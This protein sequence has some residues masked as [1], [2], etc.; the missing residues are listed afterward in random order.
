MGTRRRPL[1]LRR[2]IAS[3][4]V[5]A[6]ACALALPALASAQTFVVDTL[7]DETSSS[8]YACEFGECSLRDAITKANATAEEDTIEFDVEGTIALGVD[9][10]PLITQPLEIDA[11]TLEAY[12]GEPLVAIDGSNTLAEGATTGLGFLNGASGGGVEG[13]AIGGFDIG[14]FL[15]GASGASVCGN[16]VGIGLDGTTPLPNEVGIETGFHS[17]EN[18]I[19]A[20]CFGYRGNVISGN[21]SY[22]VVDFGTGTGIVNNRIGVDAEGDPDPNGRF[23]SVGAGVLVSSNAEGPFVGGHGGEGAPGNVI[24]GNEGAG[25][26]VEDGASNVSIRR[27]SIAANLLE[28]IQINANA[29]PAPVLGAT[30]VGGGQTQLAGSLQGDPNEVYDLDFFASQACDAGGSGEGQAYLGSESIE[31]DAGGSASFD[32]GGFEEAPAGSEVFTATAT[33]EA[34]G[35]TSEFS[36]CFDEPPGTTIDSLLP[37]DPTTDTSAD[38]EFSGTDP[39]GEVAGFECNFNGGGFEPC[40]SPAHYGE[41]G[42]GVDSFEV[43]AVDKAGAVDPSPASYSW[44][45][46]NT[47]PAITIEGRPPQPSNQDSAEF[48]FSVEDAASG[49]DTVECRI[50]SGALSPCDSPVTYEALADGTHRFEVW[51]T[52][53]VGHTSVDFVDWTVDATAPT[54]T[55]ES[56][57]ADPSSSSAPAF[58]FVGGDTGTGVASFECKLDA[59]AF[60]AC[61]SPQGYT[62]VADGPHSFEVRAVD[63]AGNADATPATYAWTVETAAPAAPQLTGTAPGSPASDTSPAVVGSA[64][65]GTTVSL[66]GTGDCSGTPLTT[67]ATPAQLATGVAVTVVADSVTEFS[68]KATSPAAVSSAC[69]SPLSYREDSTAP[70]TTIDDPKPADPSSS[71]A[72]SLQFSGGDPGGSGVAGF[73]CRLDAAPFAACTSPQN[74]SG[75]VDGSHSFEVRAIDN[76]GNVDPTPAAFSWKVEPPAPTQAATTLALTNATVIPSNGDT[77]AVAPQEGKVFVQRPGQKKPTELKEGETIPVGSIVDATSG[78]VLLTSVN[79]AGETQSAV[80]YGGKFLVV[81]HDG[82]GLVILKLRG[83]DLSGCA[84]TARAPRASTLAIAP[85]GGKGRRL[86]GSGHGNFRT[87]GNYGSATVRGT[88][89]FTE[90]RCDGTFFKVKRGIVAIRDFTTGKSV[91]LP[92]GKTYLAKP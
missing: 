26:L 92:A 72:A 55:I 58:T 42:D 32:F 17:E 70:T 54:T 30:T 89:W 81:Q 78:K 11:T 3:A 87:E 15:A 57:P 83:G 65:A 63:G 38:F 68:A 73:E 52:D 31:T 20:E 44:T 19:G 41:L 51:A 43:R 76:A 56:K 45:V 75:L 74:F 14:L 48:T 90:D 91:S 47:Y 79:V 5:L 9:P 24:A 88:I 67:T 16:Y 77:V 84:G 46:D 33:A 62:D 23:N 39:D 82:S 35:A 25:V 22:G 53:N 66:Y 29:G 34:S 59:G 50:D 86:W 1:A 61:T 80:F 28:G 13:L 12:E 4:I 8:P 7:E 69:S 18:R 71:A 10:L 2:Q 64:P 36:Q 27:N 85:R 60:A 21:L 40:T 49:I 6:L 37:T